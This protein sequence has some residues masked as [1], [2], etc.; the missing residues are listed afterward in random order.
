MPV[1]DGFEPE[2][3]IGLVKGREAL[4]AQVSI[5]E[6]SEGIAAG[7]GRAAAKI[8]RKRAP[9][10]RRWR[11]AAIGLRTSAVFH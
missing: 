2:P 11:S 1:G 6:P 10:P 8:A 4:G 7:E 5:G 9:A 3:V